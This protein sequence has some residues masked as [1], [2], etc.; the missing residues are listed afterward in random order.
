M[1]P[2]EPLT[3]E[4]LNE[5]S[6]KQL[7]TLALEIMA[8]TLD[9]S[10]AGKNLSAIAARIAGEDM[11]L[12]EEVT[13]LAK[14]RAALNAARVAGDSSVARDVRTGEVLPRSRSVVDD[15]RPVTAGS[16]RPLP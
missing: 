4:L 15:D 6:D 13:N 5:L 10:V 3:E 11:V 8:R 12:P 16:T 9:G 14:K 1:A 7:L 2:P